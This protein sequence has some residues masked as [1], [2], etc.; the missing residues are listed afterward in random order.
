MSY[1]VQNILKSI[2]R[3]FQG[4]KPTIFLH[5]NIGGMDTF[6]ANYDVV[7]HL[8]VH[9][10]SDFHIV[11]CKQ[12]SNEYLLKKVSKH[13]D[14][15]TAWLNEKRF[16]SRLNHQ[17][18]VQ[19]IDYFED[20]H[21]SYFVMEYIPGPDLHTIV[22]DNVEIPLSEN[23]L[24]H[25]FVQMGDAIRYL[26]IS[27]IAHCDI[28]LENF[29]ICDDHIKLIDFG[30]ARNSVGRTVKKGGTCFYLSP[31]CLTNIKHDICTDDIWA[32]GICLYTCIYR[33]YPFY[34]D[35]NGN[36][37]MYNNIIHDEPNYEP[38]PS[39]SCVDL[40][41][42]ALTKNHNKR[43]NIHAFCSH[44]WFSATD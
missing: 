33:L 14:Q 35:D 20:P 19:Y 32:L 4:R 11:S 13:E 36:D 25:W 18:I 39:Q 23:Q 21:F 31:E 29:V 3:Y 41:Q 6:L 10:N 2:T 16:I 27:Y 44:I 8:D 37:A 12:S 7:R 40:M 5:D 9:S 43:M 30:L 1:L 26:H 22:L 17:N 42:C 15:P 34:G 28:K 38:P 24:R